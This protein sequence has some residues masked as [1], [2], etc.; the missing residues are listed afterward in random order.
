MVKNSC[1]KFSSL[2]EINFIWWWQSWRL[3]MSSWMQSLRFYIF[4]IRNLL[5]HPVSLEQWEDP[6]IVWWHSLVFVFLFL[7]GSCF[8]CFSTAPQRRLFL[9][10]F[11]FASLIEYFRR[12]WELVK[13]G[14]CVTYNSTVTLFW[15]W[16][17]K[18]FVIK[19]ITFIK[20]QSIWFM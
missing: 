15:W 16:S 8:H 20:Q 14:W 10:L 18:I 19:L 6:V 5:L 4:W 11:I 2:F 17:F 1:Q 12:R 7:W 13:I 9:R 3:L